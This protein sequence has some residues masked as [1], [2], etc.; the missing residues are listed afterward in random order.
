MTEKRNGSRLPFKL[1]VIA[2][3]L[4]SDRLSASSARLHTRDL[5]PQGAG[6]EWNLSPEGEVCG[7]CHEAPRG[8]D[9]PKPSC[10]SLV[11][12]EVLLNNG[13]LQIQG[14]H[15]VPGWEGEDKVLGKVTWIQWVK[16]SSAF[17]FGI[18]FNRER[19][20]I[21]DEKP[22]A[23]D[24]SALEGSVSEQVFDLDFS[25][26]DGHLEDNKGLIWI[27]GENPLETSGLLS[28][29]KSIGCSARSGSGNGES[30]DQMFSDK[31]KLIFVNPFFNHELKMDFVEKLE[32]SCRSAK[33]VLLADERSKFK[34]LED[35]KVGF[36][37]SLLVHPVDAAALK[38]LLEEIELQS[39]TSLKSL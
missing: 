30:L 15:D 26:W 32:R 5:H 24:A 19:P 37:R 27:V 4:G 2:S 38:N 25:R 14:L 10:P 29:L 35:P 22:L 36:S 6:F 11:F 17:Q 31:P 34:I 1:S 3:P 21:L 8:L 33:L 28:L 7:L 39:L 13:W 20:P 23:A 18:R 12:K 16:E 9:C